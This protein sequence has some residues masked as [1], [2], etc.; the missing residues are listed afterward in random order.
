MYKWERKIN[1][2]K[3][4]VEDGG[5]SPKKGQ[6]NKAASRDEIGTQCV[7]GYPLV[8]SKTTTHP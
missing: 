6:V 3:S 7:Q 5:V 2:H 4:K 8:S 1:K